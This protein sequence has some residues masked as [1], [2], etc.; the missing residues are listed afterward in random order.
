MER[1]CSRIASIKI[2]MIQNDTEKIIMGKRERERL[3]HVY[4]L[5]LL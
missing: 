2:G 3:T 1:E 5:K 4:S